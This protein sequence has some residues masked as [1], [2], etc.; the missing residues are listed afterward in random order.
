M[1]NAELQAYEA[2]KGIHR[3]MKKANEPNWEQR[4]YEIAKDCLASIVGN[5]ETNDVSAVKY[6]VGLTDK[7]QNVVTDVD[8]R[9]NVSNA[10]LLKSV[11]NIRRCLHSIVNVGN[12]D[13]AVS[14]NIF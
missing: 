7:K 12:F 9:V 1:T 8:D 3:E 2:V 4:R 14:V 6:V 13:T 5:Y 10:E 11:K